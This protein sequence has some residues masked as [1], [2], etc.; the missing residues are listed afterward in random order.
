MVCIRPVSTRT[1]GCSVRRG[2]V[3]AGGA[4]DGRASW[5]GG[6]E[7]G[8]A[9]FVGAAEGDCVNRSGTGSGPR[10]YVLRAGKH[11]VDGACWRG[12]G[13]R[14]VVVMVMRWWCV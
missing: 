5:R 7:G 1:M 12:G 6:G 13:W 2:I 4:L 9:V 11:G 8:R 10:G 14:A 3:A